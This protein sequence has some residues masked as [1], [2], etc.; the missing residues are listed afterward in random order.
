MTKAAFYFYRNLHSD[1]FSIKYGGKVVERLTRALI[2]SA[3][4]KVNAKGREKVRTLKVK[5]VHAYVLT[6]DGYI[7]NLECAIEGYLSRMFTTGY[8]A[9][10]VIYNPYKNDAF[11][12]ADTGEDVEGHKTV[13]LEYPKVYVI[14]RVA[15]YKAGDKIDL[16]PWPGMTGTV[17]SSDLHTTRYTLDGYA[18]EHTA[19]IENYNTALHKS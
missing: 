9:R 11:V 19:W 5:H 2:P 10:E 18:P 12:Y 7:R 14:E 15:P 3:G 6:D 8:V 4:F 13:L 1:V 16:L 17:T